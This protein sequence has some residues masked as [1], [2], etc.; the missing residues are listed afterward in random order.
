MCASLRPIPPKDVCDWMT[1]CWFSFLLRDNH[2]SRSHY[3]ESWR[4][5]TD[6]VRNQG[7]VRTG[8]TLRGLRTGTSCTGSSDQS[9][10]P[11]C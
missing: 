6:A 7:T 8:G 10:Y 11:F 2:E 5:E 3:L 1:A 4:L 9:Y